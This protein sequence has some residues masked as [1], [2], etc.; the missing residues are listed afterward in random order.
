MNVVRLV[1]ADN[2]QVFT[3]TPFYCV[4]ERAANSINVL[5]RKWI[6]TYFF[7]NCFIMYVLLNLHLLASIILAEK[8]SS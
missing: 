2:I 7:L 6:L 5:L 1:V 8:N 4:L 3:V